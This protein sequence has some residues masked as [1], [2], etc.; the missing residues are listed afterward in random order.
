MFIFTNVLGAFVFDENLEIADKV[1]FYNASDFAKREETA[2]ELAG[3][4]EAK[5]PN[6]ETLKKILLKFKSPDHLGELYRMNLLSTSFDVKNSVTADLLISHA[7]NNHE[8]IGRN[9]ASLSKRLREWYDLYCPEVS[10]ANSDNEKFASR[11]MKYSKK[12]LLEELEVKESLGSEFKEED[13]KPMLE[14]ASRIHSLCESIK[15]LEEYAS[16]LMEKLCPNIKA[17]CG[18]MIGAKLIEHAGSLKR[19]SEMP[20]STIQILGA[21]TALF[22]HLKTG[23][24]P[25]RHGLI[26]N[27]P[28]ISQAPDRLH[29]K[30]ARSVADKISIAS[31]VDYFKGEFIGGKLKEQLE[32]KVNA[33]I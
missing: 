7:I 3:K 33:L 19:L 13:V 17:V 4:H 18:T 8:E 15:N 24:R 1:M 25:P 12:N 27:H 11:I 20:S 26:V 10:R 21:E 28:L 23:A 30:I 14:I 31:K 9:I 29:G 6:S 32:N 2:K 22:R 16:G 5:A